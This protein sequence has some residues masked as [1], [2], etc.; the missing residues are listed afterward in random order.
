M[1]R[2]YLLILTF[3][4]LSS[5]SNFLLAQQNSFSKDFLERW[6][7][8]RQ[9]MLSVAEAMPE[10]EY[11]FKPTPEEMSFAEQLM[12]IAVVIDWHAFSKADGQ[13][14]KP[15][16]EDFEVAGRSKKEM[17]DM[18]NKEFDRAA[19][20]IADFKPK[21]L[22][23]KGSYGKF[24]RTRQQFFMLM[25]DHV[26]HHRAQMLVYLRLKGITPPKYVEFQ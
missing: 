20:L 7:T 14:F 11:G 15:R 10:S 9:Y 16:W 26:T 24:T 4:T 5:I 6:E 21:R 8:S 1:I 25:T 17:I 12:H 18:T 2:K 3:I 19:K 22:E 13:E 23:E